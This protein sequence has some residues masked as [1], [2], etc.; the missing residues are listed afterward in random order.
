MAHRALP[1]EM[2][3]M[4]N[5]SEV[6]ELRI[7]KSAGLEPPFG[8]RAKMAMV[9]KSV[10]IDGEPTHLLT[11]PGTQR[12]PNP[13][14]LWSMWNVVSQYLSLR[15]CNTRQW[16][17]RPSVRKE[18]GGAG[19]GCRKKRKLRCHG[20]DRGSRFALTRKGADFQCRCDWTTTT[21]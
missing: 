8:P 15:G 21:R 1:W 19:R 4:D 6:L 10:S 14:Y 12:R 17:S 3:G 16:W 7:V 13:I 5:V 20:G 18:N 11:H 2:V 9:G